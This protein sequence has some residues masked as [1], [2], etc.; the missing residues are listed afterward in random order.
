MD[1]RFREYIES[2]PP[3]FDQLVSMSPT[4]I[5]K[6]P[7]RLPE[8]CV[9][10]FSE[11]SR[12]LYAG[13]TNHFRQRMRNHST[14]SAKENQA[15]FA[16]RLA[17]EATGRKQAGYR[18]AMLEDPEFAEAFRRSKERIRRMQLRFVD[19]PDQLRQALLEIYVAVA[20]RTPHNDFETH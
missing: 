2:L 4:S 15:V 10:L 16:F 8:Q 13:R 3:R 19:E 5:E 9:Y 12:H 11:D 6:L 20:L 18:R 14:P 17:Q 1:D 7:K